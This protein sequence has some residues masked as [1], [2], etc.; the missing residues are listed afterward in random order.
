MLISRAS[1]SSYVAIHRGKPLS[2]G[3]LAFSVRF[4]DWSKRGV[5]D[6]GVHEDVPRQHLLE[7]LSN[8]MCPLR[9]SFAKRIPDG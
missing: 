2:P 5:K 1:Y 8:S 7:N 3:G 9:A 6:L 4:G